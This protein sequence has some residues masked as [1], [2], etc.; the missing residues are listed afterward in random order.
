MSFDAVPEELSLGTGE[1]S[2]RLRNLRMAPAFKVHS[3]I[4]YLLRSKVSQQRGLLG[5]V[6][7]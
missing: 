7:V 3:Y 6:L 2:V 5:P 1:T 4:K